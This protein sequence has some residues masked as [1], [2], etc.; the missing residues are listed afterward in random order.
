MTFHTAE[1]PIPADLQVDIGGH[2]SAPILSPPISSAHRDGI[3]IRQTFRSE[4]LDMD[5]KARK[6]G[7]RVEDMKL[8][9]DADGPY[10]ELRSDT[11]K[12]AAKQQTEL[13]V[14]VRLA[15]IYLS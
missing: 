8:I 11:V 10:L 3:H 4:S 5:E 7:M 15:F 14:V 1:V 12:T 13:A 9:I 2:Q 6:A